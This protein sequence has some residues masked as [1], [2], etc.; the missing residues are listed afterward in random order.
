[1]TLKLEPSIIVHAGRRARVCEALTVL[2]LGRIQLGLRACSGVTGE[3]AA[4]SVSI[5]QLINCV[6]TLIVVV[7][8]VETGERNGARSDMVTGA[9]LESTHSYLVCAAY[10]AKPVRKHIETVLERADEVQTR[11]VHG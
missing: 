10:L 1:M 3:S 9:R 6:P 4:F 2:E 7:P 11:G 5:S 8:A